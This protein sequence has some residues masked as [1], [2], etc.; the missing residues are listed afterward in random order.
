MLIGHV[1]SSTTMHA[2]DAL[3][4]DCTA[5]ICTGLFVIQARVLSIK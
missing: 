2:D 3:E 5:G 1:L 4:S